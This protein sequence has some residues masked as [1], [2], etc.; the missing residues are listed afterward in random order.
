[1]D[2]CLC[3]VKVCVAKGR[4]DII[5]YPLSVAVDQSTSRF[6]PPLQTRQT[7]ITSLVRL[8]VRA[9]VPLKAFIRPGDG[10]VKL[11]TT[12]LKLV[13][14]PFGP[15]RTLTL[16]LSSPGGQVRD[17]YTVAEF[18]ELWGPLLG[19]SP[20]GMGQCYF[21]AAKFHHRWGLEQDTT[22]LPRMPFRGSKPSW[23][24]GPMLSVRRFSSA[25]EGGF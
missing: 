21:T 5:P 25:C 14:V 16:S 9:T 12:G 23:K 19:P 20:K 11:S 15:G 17:L 2:S 7:T 3:L 4:G 10:A 18:H 1:V 6:T 24:L 8:H 22:L 13:G